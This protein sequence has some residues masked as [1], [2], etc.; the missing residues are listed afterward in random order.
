MPEQPIPIG[1]R[2]PITSRPSAEHARK[3]S[4]CL[5]LFS[6]M[7]DKTFAIEL[8]HEALLSKS[9]Y[10]AQAQYTLNLPGAMQAEQQLFDLQNTMYSLRAAFYAVQTKKYGLRWRDGDFDIIA[11]PEESMGALFIPLMIGAVILAGCFATLYSIGKSSDKLMVDYK[12]LNKAADSALC[13]D[14]NSDLCKGWN[15]VKTQ[16][17]IEEKESFADTLKG[18]LS[19]GITIALALVGGL[20]ALSIWR[21]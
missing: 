20:V 14:P 16:Q 21:K 10:A 8:Q 15:V 2:A 18:G 11:P 9:A 4:E 13:S 12:V 1:K 19:K 6:D 5:R 7:E 3:W 17:H